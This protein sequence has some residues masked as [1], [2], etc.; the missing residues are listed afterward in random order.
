MQIPLHSD[1]CVLYAWLAPFLIL[2][3]AVLS[4]GVMHAQERPEGVCRLYSTSNGYISAVTKSVDNF[5]DSWSLV[6]QVRYKSQSNRYGFL[7][8][9]DRTQGKCI[10]YDDSL[11]KIC[12]TYY[13]WE[14]N[15]VSIMAADMNL[16]GDDEILLFTSDQKLII[17]KLSR[18]GTFSLSTLKIIPINPG[19]AST[20]WSDAFV[21]NH[22]TGGPVQLFFYGRKSNVT[23]YQLCSISPH[24]YSLSRIVKAELAG[25]P[26]K[27]FVPVTFYD[28][29]PGFMVFFANADTGSA[30]G[31]MEGFKY[32]ETDN[33]FGPVLYYSN[34]PLV[35]KS[36]SEV[37]TGNFGSGRRFGDMMFYERGSRKET[38]FSVRDTSVHLTHSELNAEGIWSFVIP[39]RHDQETTSLLFYSSPNNTL[40]DIPTYDHSDQ[41]MHA[42]ILAEGNLYKLA[43]TP[44]PNSNPAF[45][46]PSLLES[47]DGVSFHPVTGVTTPMAG[48]PKI[49]SPY[50]AAYNDD[51]DLFLSGG[52]EYLVFQES[53]RND[54]LG[55]WDQNIWLY[56]SG[57]HFVHKTDSLVIFHEHL[58]D[59]T[60]TLSPAMI[61]SAGLGKVFYMFFIN[62]GEIMY[63]RSTD[64]Y[65]WDGLPMTA[66]RFPGFHP[67]HIEVVYNPFDAFYYLLITGK[68]FGTSSGIKNDL[69]FA[70]SRDLISWAL[71]PWPGIKKTDLACSQI[72]RSSGV[73]QNANT[74]SIWYS[75]RTLSGQWGMAFRR[76][77]EIDPHHFFLPSIKDLSTTAIRENDLQGIRIFPNPAN[78]LLSIEWIAPEFSEVPDI[79]M[80]D[81]QGR[82]VMKFSKSHLPLN[83]NV[84]GLTN[85]IYRLS[86][87]SVAE[88]I[89]R[90][91][92]VMH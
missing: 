3:A 13:N 58:P 5:S 54:S 15:I 73:F 81:M 47:E 57:D 86:V 89:C 52:K 33:Y 17:R 32:I 23:A 50:N 92:A 7:F 84:S 61:D 21:F 1:R 66:I 83:I 29:R 4:P 72:Y 6:C 63:M 25:D 44:Y 28:Y 79:R 65:H 36:I 64:M 75:Y 34:N 8:F 24:D 27:K 87:S 49:A 43:C 91:V 30:Y 42:S 51:P 41:A 62:R 12:A 60:I 18:D 22:F 20:T 80:Y 85:G 74:L 55:I 14:K 53:L 68:D 45:E 10:V 70:K 67:W 48:T 26:V 69:Y 2:A 78:D 11:T 35:P 40:L 37:I 90:D 82:M 31:V 88:T 39:V 46:N 76:Y 9:Y 56:G 71:N 16:D 77:V 38:F 19:D 59:S